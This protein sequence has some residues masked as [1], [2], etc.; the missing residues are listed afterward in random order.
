MVQFGGMIP[1]SNHGGRYPFF[2]TLR[3]S[4]FKLRNIFLSLAAFFVVRNLIKFVR[5]HEQSQYLRDSGVPKEDMKQYVATTA[6]ERE[7][8]KELEKLKKDVAYL[9]K[10]VEELKLGRSPSRDNPPDDGRAESFRDIDRVHEQKRKM[11]E[12]QLLKDHP[13]FKPSKRLKDFLEEPEQNQN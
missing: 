8:D 10:E 3:L 11:H 6:L 1:R 12:E 4:G 7:K 13:N 2:R 5:V 9:M